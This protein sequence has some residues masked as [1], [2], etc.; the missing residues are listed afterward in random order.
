MLVALSGWLPI[1]KRIRNLFSIR[2]QRM[3]GSSAP[4]QMLLRH[5]E[6]HSLAFSLSMPKAP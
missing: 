6:G 3:I 1:R 5:S 2:G 4:P